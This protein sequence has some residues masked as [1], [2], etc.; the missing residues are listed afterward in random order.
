VLVKRQGKLL[1]LVDRIAEL[2][3][4]AWPLAIRKGESS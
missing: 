4:I 3:M 2:R 1:Q